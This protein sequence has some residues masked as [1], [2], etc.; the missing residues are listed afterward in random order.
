MKINSFIVILMDGIYAYRFKFK[1]DGIDQ[2]GLHH[3]HAWT[4]LIACE[5]NRWN[6]ANI[7]VYPSSSLKSIYFEFYLGLSWPLGYRSWSA[8]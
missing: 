1:D 8:S 5:G 4:H 3:A 6:Y 2:T 7:V